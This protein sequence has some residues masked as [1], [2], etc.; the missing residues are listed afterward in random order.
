VLTFFQSTMDTLNL[1][2]SSRQQVMDSLRQPPD[3]R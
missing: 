1:P 2:E 3:P